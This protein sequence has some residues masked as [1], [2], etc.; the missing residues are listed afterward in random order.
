MVK[1]LTQNR[2][3]TQKALFNA[4]KFACVE[5]LLHKFFFK[6]KVSKNNLGKDVNIKYGNIEFFHGNFEF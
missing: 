1:K 3:S 2:H 5:K 6:F 4:T